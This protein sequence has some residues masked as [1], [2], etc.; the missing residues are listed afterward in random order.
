MCSLMLRD[1]FS[2]DNNLQIL[3]LLLDTEN[4]SLQADHESIV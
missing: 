3:N 1:L 4:N 2:A